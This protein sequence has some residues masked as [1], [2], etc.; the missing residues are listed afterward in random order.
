M[1]SPFFLLKIKNDFFKNKKFFNIFK[2]P[3][4]YY[5]YIVA[6]HLNLFEDNK[7][8]YKNG[9]QRVQLHSENENVRNIHPVKIDPLKN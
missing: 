7:F 5:L 9:Y 2:L 4:I 6:L 3:F 8:Y 1:Y